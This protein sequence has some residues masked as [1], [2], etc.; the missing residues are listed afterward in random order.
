ME[1]G[2]NTSLPVA[3]SISVWTLQTWGQAEGMDFMI[4]CNFGV[5]QGVPAKNH[6]NSQIDLA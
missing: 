1:G 5:V 2:I 6:N 4:C 3:A